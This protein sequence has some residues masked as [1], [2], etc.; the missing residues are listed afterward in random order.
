MTRSK[1]ASANA[2]AV[3]RPIPLAAPVIKATRRFCVIRSP[4]RKYVVYGRSAFASTL[5][6]IPLLRD[7]SLLI[8]SLDRLGL[9]DR[10]GA[11][12]RITCEYVNTYTLEHVQLDCQGLRRVWRW[13]PS[14]TCQN[15]YYGDRA[16]EIT[17]S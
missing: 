12:S 7:N 8:E 2:T 11:A 14:H 10:G 13:L 5:A 15:R 16:C 1:L 17:V 3:A 9:D 4:A 6:L